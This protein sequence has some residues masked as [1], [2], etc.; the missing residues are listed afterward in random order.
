MP[1]VEAVLRRT[2]LS[3][4]VLRETERRGTIKGRVDP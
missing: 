1:S 3:E 4:I 2:I